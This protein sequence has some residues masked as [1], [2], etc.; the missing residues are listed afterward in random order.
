MNILLS[1]ISLIGNV[2]GLVL[3]ALVM[4]SALFGGK[5]QVGTFFTWEPYPLLRKSKRRYRGE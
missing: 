5:W 2:I 1:I 3:S 4:A